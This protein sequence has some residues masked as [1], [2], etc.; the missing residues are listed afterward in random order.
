[1]RQFCSLQTPSF[2]EMVCA[3]RLPGESY[4]RPFQILIFHHLFH[5]IATNRNELIASDV[6][7]NLIVLPCPTM[8]LKKRKG[9]TQIIRLMISINKYWRRMRSKILFHFLLEPGNISGL[10]EVVSSYSSGHGFRNGV[11]YLGGN[12]GISKETRG[13]GLEGQKGYLDRLKVLSCTYFRI[14]PMLLSFQS[15]ST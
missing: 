9:E 15:N 3:D 10:S 6:L 12:P 5:E 2:T 13:S 7:T 1:M 14:T 8:W 4:E 11:I